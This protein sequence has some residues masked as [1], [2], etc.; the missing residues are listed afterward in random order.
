LGFISGCNVISIGLHVVYFL[1][2]TM[3]RYA[4]AQKSFL[5]S[6]IPVCSKKFNIGCADDENGWLTVKI[7]KGIHPID[8]HGGPVDIATVRDDPKQKQI[9][10]KKTQIKNTEGQS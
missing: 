6:R 4:K 8:K 7:R 10:V 2:L 5:Q 3:D 1:T 9:H